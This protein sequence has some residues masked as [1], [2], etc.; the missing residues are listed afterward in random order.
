MGISTGPQL[1]AKN[2][3]D[4][5]EYATNFDVNYLA[6]RIEWLELALKKTVLENDKSVKPA[7]VQGRLMD[8][9][10]DVWENHRRNYDFYLNFLKS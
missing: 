2:C 6:S 8:A 1:N 3:F 4:V 10:D 7:V 5:G 9:I